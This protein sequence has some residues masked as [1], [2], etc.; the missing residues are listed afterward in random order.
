MEPVR[1]NIEGE[2]NK[3]VYK[4]IRNSI[5]PSCIN[6]SSSLFNINVTDIYTQLVDKFG[7]EATWMSQ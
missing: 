7:E 2:Y 1:K 4:S 3:L 5:S 6:K